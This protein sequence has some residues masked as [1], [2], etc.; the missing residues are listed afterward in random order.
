MVSVQRA[1]LSVRSRGWPCS[2]RSLW[3]NSTAPFLQFEKSHFASSPAGEHSY[4]GTFSRAIGAQVSEHLAGLE[5]KCDFSNCRNGAVE[6]R[7][8]DRFEHG[9]PLERTDKLA[10][11]TETI[12]LTPRE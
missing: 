9:H 8:S 6:F 4:G 7:Q 5:A 12:L 11:C 2:K 3:R 1:S 10:P